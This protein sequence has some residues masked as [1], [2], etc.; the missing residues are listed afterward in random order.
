M[1]LADRFGVWPLRTPPHEMT[2]AQVRLLAEAL[3][4]ETPGDQPPRDEPPRFPK[5]YLEQFVKARKEK[6]D[7]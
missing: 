2:A 1:L 4:A 7:G 3:H 6:R 5:S